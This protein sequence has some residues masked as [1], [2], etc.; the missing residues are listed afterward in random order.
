MQESSSWMPEQVENA[1]P[2]RKILLRCG[3][4]ASIWAAVALL[5]WDAAIWGSFVL[6]AIVCPIWFLVSI[7]KNIIRRPGW[8]LALL[9]I[10]IPPMT[11]GLIMANNAVQLK[12]AK[13]NAP[14]VVAACEEFHAANGG[15][16]KTLDELV[17]RY[18]PSIPCAKYCVTGKFLYLNYQDHPLLIWYTFPVF[19]KNV[20]NFEKRQWNYID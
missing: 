13:A 20:Y 9:R 8:R 6:S 10:A 19:G 5:V 14:R 1:S 4:K 15:F 11:L 3:I 16:P 12:I 17:P 2:S 18:L 7:V